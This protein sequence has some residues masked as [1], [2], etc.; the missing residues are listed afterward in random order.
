[1]WRDDAKK[2]RIMFEHFFSARLCFA[3]RIQVGEEKTYKKMII[4][5]Q[6]LTIFLRRFQ[7]IGYQ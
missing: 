6:E 5:M 3:R 7:G 1:M 2:N 4:I